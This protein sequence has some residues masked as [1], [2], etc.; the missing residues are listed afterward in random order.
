[1][2]K[3]KLSESKTSSRQP[4]DLVN[5]YLKEIGCIPLLAP[6]QEIILAKQVQRM[7]SVLEKKEQL[8]KETQIIL[9][10]QE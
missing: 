10:N 7:M 6:E 1:M 3:A 5:A 9:D 2:T 8:E 4:K